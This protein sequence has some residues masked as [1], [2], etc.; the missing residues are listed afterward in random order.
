[1]V[2]ILLWYNS[3]GSWNTVKMTPRDKL[4][5]YESRVREFSRLKQMGVKGI[6]ID[7]FGGD[8]QSMIN[9]Y[10]DILEDAATY[11]LLVN[12]HGATLPR[13]LQRTYPNFVTA[14]AV[15]GYEMITFNQNDANLFPQHA[16]MVAMVRNAFDP[17]DFTPM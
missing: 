15:Q 10:Q 17:M 9:Y 13:G 8:G 2:G 5:T 3:A 16:I 7:F 12:F 4:L 1:N 14:E 6:K 11:K